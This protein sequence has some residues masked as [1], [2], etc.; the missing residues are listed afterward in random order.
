MSGKR[1]KEVKQVAKRQALRSMF[2]WAF[3]LLIVGGSL[4]GLFKLAF[5]PPQT[6][7]TVPTPVLAREH[8]WFKGRKDAKVVLIE[9]SDFQCPACGYFF[10]ILRELESEFGGQVKF[11][12]RHFPLTQIH[13]NA[14]LAALAAEAAG[15]QGKFWEMHDV[16]FENQAEW[17]NQPNPQAT[18]VEYATRIGIDE[19]RFQQDLLRG[20]VKQAVEKDQRSGEQAGV[21]ATPTFFLN[22]RKLIPLPRDGDEFRAVLTQAL[23]RG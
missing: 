17:S 22:G 11:I 6:L 16:I 3:A 18:F 12:Y 21:D 2:I 15:R 20:A 8:D 19:Q 23:H 5:R 14:E 1:Q 4:Y 13:P 7:P 9:Y 10:P